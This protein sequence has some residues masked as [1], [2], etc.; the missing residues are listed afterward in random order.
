MQAYKVED[1]SRF[2]SSLFTLG[3]LAIF[4][5]YL[6]NTLFSARQDASQRETFRV[7]ADT[8][9]GFAILHSVRVEPVGCWRAAV[10]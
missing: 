8:V 5:Y 7:D 1:L 9:G 3:H 6:G 2:L 4:L 10:H